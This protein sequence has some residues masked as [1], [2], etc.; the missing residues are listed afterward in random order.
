MIWFIFL[1]LALECDRTKVPP[2]CPSWS[3]I[4]S[5]INLTPIF[6]ASPWEVLLRLPCLRELEVK[7]FQLVVTFSFYKTAYSL[8][9]PF[10]CHTECSFAFPN[11]L[12][13]TSRAALW[14][15]LLSRELLDGLIKSLI[16]TL[17]LFSGPRATVPQHNFNELCF[18]EYAWE[19]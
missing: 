19:T 2:S 3:H 16:Q 1:R 6:P 11:S 8:F 10:N 12:K 17:V 14:E 13:E 7:I 5:D 9:V 18:T 15:L 4:R